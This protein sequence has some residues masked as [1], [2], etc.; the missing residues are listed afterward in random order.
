MSELQQT[1]TEDSF[2]V[3]FHQNA[4]HTRLICCFTIASGSWCGFFFQSIV[5]GKLMQSI[6]LWSLSSVPKEV[7]ISELSS[8]NY[9]NFNAT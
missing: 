6:S 4:T 9:G 5:R 2:H 1:V 3:I 7:I 8:C